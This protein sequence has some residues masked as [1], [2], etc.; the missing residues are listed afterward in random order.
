MQSEWLWSVLVSR[1]FDKI[2]FYQGHKANCETGLVC[3][4]K[5]KKCMKP[6]QLGEDCSVSV[7]L[8][9]FQCYKL[10]IDFNIKE[11]PCEKSLKCKKKNKKCVPRKGNGKRK[12]KG[13][14][15]GKGKN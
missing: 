2:L 4:K 7:H 15:K 13:K 5:K 9:S 1:K 11:S 6:V 3:S 12:G 14:G 8:I 10:T